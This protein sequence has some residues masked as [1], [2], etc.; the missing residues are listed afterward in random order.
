MKP[1]KE[2][3][4][5]AYNENQHFNIPCCVIDNPNLSKM[6]T[7]E[8]ARVAR[9]LY[10]D[11]VSFDAH[12]EKEDRYKIYKISHKINNNPNVAFFTCVADR[13]MEYIHI[14]VWG[15]EALLNSAGLLGENNGDKMLELLIKD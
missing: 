1:N 8:G 7:G 9:E 6:L 2:E 5:N 13:T 3:L 12:I 14:E 11:Y 4:M 15:D 10:K